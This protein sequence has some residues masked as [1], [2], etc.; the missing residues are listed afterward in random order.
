[1]SGGSM[2]ITVPPRD[3]SEP[4]DAQVRAFSWALR[5]WKG[6]GETVV[7]KMHNGRLLLSTCCQGTWQHTYIR[8][9]GSNG[10]WF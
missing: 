9:D 4:T 5:I 3:K 6:E 8:P 2:T 1:M 10:V 7:G